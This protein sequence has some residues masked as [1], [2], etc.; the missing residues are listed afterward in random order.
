MNLYQ[1]HYKKS[2]I[3]FQ[4]GPNEKCNI[5][6]DLKFNL[7]NFSFQSGP[8]D[9]IYCCLWCIFSQFS[10]VAKINGPQLAHGLEKGLKNPPKYVIEVKG[11]TRVMFWI[12]FCLF[13]N[14]TQRPQRKCSFIK[15]LM[16]FDKNNSRY[17]CIYVMA[18]SKMRA[19]SQEAKCNSN[20]IFMFLIIQF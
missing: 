16:F 14:K 8:V 4:S 18:C 3:S 9:C 10:K 15:M 6:F 5:F 7:S 19:S 20:Y 13:K 11:K 2:H 12:T 1:L 17:T